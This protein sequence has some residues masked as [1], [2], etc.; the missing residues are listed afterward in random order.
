[1]KFAE[2]YVPAVFC[3]RACVIVYLTKCSLQSIRNGQIVACSI[4]YVIRFVKL[5]EA[6]MSIYSNPETLVREPLFRKSL[7]RE[8]R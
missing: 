6:I 3:K 1:M 2:R 5:F 8:K 7:D 4:L